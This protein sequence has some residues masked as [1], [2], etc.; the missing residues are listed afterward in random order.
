M[1]GDDLYVQFYDETIGGP[2]SYKA[3]APDGSNPATYH[4]GE[5]ITD[6]VLK[7]N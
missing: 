2:R 7:P 6:K 4:G 1:E 5:T 3:A